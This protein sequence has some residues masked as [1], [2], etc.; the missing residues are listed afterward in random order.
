MKVK[1]I[2]ILLFLSAT[3]TILV[4]GQGQKKPRTEED[5]TTRTLRE[6]SALQPPVF[7]KALKEQ[8]DKDLVIIVHGDLLPS[9]VKVVYEGKTRPLNEKK[10]NV[11]LSWSNRFAGMPELYTVPYQTEALFTENGENF[12]LAVRTESLPKLDQELKRGE[13]VEL[14]VIKMGNT[15]IEKTDDKLEP[16]LLVEKYRKQ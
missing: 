15:R 1:S 7:E 8:D 4:L 14:F 2:L 10:K 9:R 16:V 13:A 11:I 6:L 3:T 5:Y 12:W